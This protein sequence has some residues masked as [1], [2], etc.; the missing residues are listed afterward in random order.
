ML[1]F[2]HKLKTFL[3]FHQFLL[4]KFIIAFI[5]IISLNFFSLPYVVVIVFILIAAFNWSTVTL[6]NHYLLE[7]IAKSKFKATLISI[8]SLISKLIV[9]FV[10]YM[11]GVVSTKYNFQLAFLNISLLLFFLGILN[12]I[13]IFY[14]NRKK[15]KTA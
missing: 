11:V 8:G 5:L 2:N 13:W 15:Q 10:A 14:H 12:W 6:K 7:I 9:A 4:L 3:S 1:L